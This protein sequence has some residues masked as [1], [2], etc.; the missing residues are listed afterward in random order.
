MS[1]SMFSD[2]RIWF[3]YGVCDV[4]CGDAC[5]DSSVDLAV[6]A[7]SGYPVPKR[8]VLSLLLGHSK[9][10]GRESWCGAGETLTSTPT[11][12]GQRENMPLRP[13]NFGGAVRDNTTSL[14]KQKAKASCLNT[15]LSSSPVCESA[16]GTYHA[17]ANSCQV[18]IAVRR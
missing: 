18:T 9:Y 6:S 3:L 5:S 8:H 12:A 13:A 4:A 17:L 15:T 2:P 1:S 14:T 11:S 10:E 16:Q 7:N